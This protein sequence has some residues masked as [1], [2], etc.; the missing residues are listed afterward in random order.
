[1]HPYACAHR[2]RRLQNQI[3][4]LPDDFSCY[5]IKLLFNEFYF[6]IRYTAHRTCVTHQFLRDCCLMTAITVINKVML[7]KL[8]SLFEILYGFLLTLFLCLGLYSWN[9]CVSI[10][11]QLFYDIIISAQGDLCI[12]KNFKNIG[13]DVQKVIFR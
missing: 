5:S 12:R 7:V 1:M 11:A 13:F 2:L 8:F 4:L 9:N 10:I 6:H 3:L